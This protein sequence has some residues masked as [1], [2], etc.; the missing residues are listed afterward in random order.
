M[1]FIVILPFCIKTP[2]LHQSK[3]LHWVEFYF[4]TLKDDQVFLQQ[5]NDCYPKLDLD[6][7]DVLLSTS[8]FKKCI[9]ICW[10]L[11]IQDP[12]MYLETAKLEGKL[13]DKEHYKEYTKS[14]TKIKYVVWPALYLFCND[15]KGPLMA[16]GVVQVNWIF[17]KQIMDNVIYHHESGFVIWQ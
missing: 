4:Q 1:R 7:F 8:Y 5:M 14:G 11:V 3:N 13:L 12:P 9:D 10:N 2:V 17:W 15:E 16:K 6:M